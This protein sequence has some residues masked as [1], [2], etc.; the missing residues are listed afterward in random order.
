MKSSFI[1][2][3]DSLRALRD[4][5]RTTPTPPPPPTPTDDHPYDDRIFSDPE[6]IAYPMN[7][8]DIVFSKRPEQI[9]KSDVVG[10][11]TL[12]DLFADIPVIDLTWEEMLA[13]VSYAPYTAADNPAPFIWTARGAKLIHGS[14]SLN[15]YGVDSSAKHTLVN[16]ELKWWKD[17]TLN[18]SYYSKSPT[19]SNICYYNANRLKDIENAH[20]AID[21]ASGAAYPAP[22]LASGGS[23]SANPNCVGL[24]LDTVYP[25]RY[26]G[27][28]ATRTPS[29]YL[30]RCFHPRR[31]FLI[32][33]EVDGRAV[34][35][36]VARYGLIATQESLVLRKARFQR[37]D[38]QGFF[39]IYI[40]CSLGID[41][42]QCTDCVFE[43]AGPDTD[44]VNTRSGHGYA[45]Y[46]I[47]LFFQNRA[48][49]TTPARTALSDINVLRH[50]FIKGNTV[51]GSSFI[52]SQMARFTNSYRCVSNTFFGGHPEE[53]LEN[54]RPYYVMRGETH[55]F[56][57]H[58]NAN[59]GDAADASNGID[60]E[61]NIK[62]GTS[63]ANDMSYF[64]CPLFFVDNKFYG[65]ERAIA[66]RV[67][68]TESHESVGLE[69]SQ[70][71]F[72]GNTIRNLI[73]KQTLYDANG[74]RY[75]PY[76]FRCHGN[77]ETY[78]SVTK[79]WFVNNVIQNVVSFTH[80]LDDAR[81]IFKCKGQGI[82][83]KFRPGWNF[84]HVIRYYVGN[85]V[86]L[87]K[88]TIWN[89]WL[90]A[91]GQKERYIDGRRYDPYDP[92]TSYGISVGNN[93]KPS[94]WVIDDKYGDFPP[95]HIQ[96]KKCSNCGY[97]NAT[98]VTK[99][100]NCGK[101][102]FSTVYPED[103]FPWLIGERHYD[104]IFQKG[105]DANLELVEN[106]DED[107]I[108]HDFKNNIAIHFTEIVMGAK[109]ASQFINSPV[110]TYVFENNT[111]DLGPFC[112]GGMMDTCSISA[113]NFICRHNVF[114]ARRM[115]SV[116]TDNGTKHVLYTSKRWMKNDI[117]DPDEAEYIFNVIPIDYYRATYEEY[118]GTPTAQEIA[119]DPTLELH[120]T[121]TILVR[122]PIQ[123]TVDVSDNEFIVDDFVL[124]GNVVPTEVKFLRVKYNTTPKIYSNV[125]TLNNV[126]LPAT[127]I[128]D[129]NVIH[130]PT[131]PD[132]EQNSVILFHRMSFTNWVNYDLVPTN[133]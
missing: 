133:T 75:A 114:K 26:D 116:Y 2:L 11:L 127:V 97:G 63:Y 55:A 130:T 115:S 68:W 28:V 59:A 117:S 96:V 50:V 14:E 6:G 56:I 70:T 9:T 95:M 77:Y 100:A 129:D 10:A 20:V 121:N 32:D 23:T 17:A 93:W 13:N 24:K 43:Q 72:I 57:S 46:Y 76:H 119:A 21:N 45:A 84:A 8:G 35:G 37:K 110:Y 22:F 87:E 91:T 131:D 34:G 30:Q 74:G 5:L 132:N 60:E 122:R 48:P 38:E 102:V 42:F 79:L 49:W 7:P 85:T 106:V 78:M 39:S 25:V 113:V 12:P 40:D 103:K 81:G 54:G 16:D 123:A 112:F 66:K 118:T 104:Q 88:D 67:T 101:T 124:D 15:K 94:E 128:L 36:F 62:S 47:Y 83:Y 108:D 69:T 120:N 27:S 111:F 1:A 61:G 89:S 4:A 107:G 64:S 105:V 126:G 99:C 3:R 51:Y 65:P 92:Y 19:T 82:P 18:P 31:P 52:S 41:Q 53:N 98:T 73:V 125:V 80:M 58:T 44:N 109:E 86:T 90:D 29:T 71:Y 33:G